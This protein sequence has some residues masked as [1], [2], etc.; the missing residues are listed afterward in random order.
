[1]TKQPPHIEPRPSVPPNPSSWQAMPA[2]EAESHLRVVAGIGLTAAEVDARLGR[3]GPNRLPAAPPRSPLTVFAAQF[4]GVFVLIL[5]AAAAI[6]AAAGD[7]KDAAVILVVVLLNGGLGFYQEYKA[8]RSL[9]ALR[10]MLPRL[11]RVRRDG[12]V[13]QVATEDLVPGDVVLLEAGDRVPADARLCLSIGLEA[14]ESGLTGES[15]PV[16]K[17]AGAILVPD[18]PL[19]DRRNLVFMNTTVTRGRGEA[20][21]TATGANTARLIPFTQVRLNV[22]FGLVACVGSSGEPHPCG[23]CPAG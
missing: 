15:A 8:E 21:V 5:V 2:F 9:L 23:D 11:A 4:K 10:D 22:V 12:T 19:A 16:A 18:T 17:D 20:I 6:A 3:V 7:L 14:D 1:M 13:L